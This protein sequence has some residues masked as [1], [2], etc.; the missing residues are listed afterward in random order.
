MPRGLAGAIIASMLLVSP[1]ASAQAR[2]ADPD[3][4]LGPDKALHF[5]A[6]A[7]IA[8]GG[9]AVGAFAFDDYLGP[10]VL[11]TSLA[12]GA[13]VVKESLDAAGL[14]T[15]SWKDLTWDVIGTALGIGVSLLVH[16]ALGG[17]RGSAA[18]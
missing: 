4:W 12:L 6:S 10:I 9:Y 16:A 3:P 5:G 11:G 18:R 14:G 7:V 17:P 1:P 2:A 15:P 13:G 8:G